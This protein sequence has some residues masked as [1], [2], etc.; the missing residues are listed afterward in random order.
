V[1][2]IVAEIR[3]NASRETRGVVIDTP[4]RHIDIVPT[5]LEAAGAATDGAL[6]GLSLRDL[7]RAGSGPDRPQYFESMT[8]NLVRGWAP[9]R[10]V[11]VAKSKY[12]DLPIPELYDLVAD[13]KEA[14]NLAPK[15]ADRVQVLLSTL[16]TTASPPDRPG[17]C[18][19]RTSP[20]CARSGIRRRA[21]ID[22]YRRRTIRNAGP[23]RHRS[24][25]ATT[26]YQI[27]CRAIARY[28]SVIT[29]GRTGRRL[30]SAGARVRQDGPASDR[31]ARSRT[32]SGRAGRDIGSARH[33]P[34]RRRQQARAIQCSSTYRRP[35]QALNGLGIAYRRASLRGRRA[36]VQPCPRA[37]SATASCRLA[38]VTLKG[39]GRLER[40]R[41]FAAPQP[42]IRRRPSA[43]ISGGAYDARRRLLIHGP[44]AEAID[45][46]RGRSRHGFTRCTLSWRELAAGGRWTMR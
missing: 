16:K 22:D 21:A 2:L 40:R 23:A 1:P 3:P 46:K 7:I 34:R 43:D 36:R 33:L 31:H 19:R 18:R 25:S 10:G 13:P 37:R 17:R 12:I 26:L 29:P 9:L 11:M 14:A 30:H 28:T 20:R 24:A 15:A 4:V 38:V 41:L 45:W 39:S 8:Y 5:V 42:I 6:P 27:R 32:E 44:Q 35:C